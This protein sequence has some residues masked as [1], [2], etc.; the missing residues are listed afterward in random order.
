M[1][2]SEARETARQVTKKRVGGGKEELKSD[3]DFK[4]LKKTMAKQQT[5][6]FF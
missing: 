2:L 6:F 4:G 1:A 3:I 5:V